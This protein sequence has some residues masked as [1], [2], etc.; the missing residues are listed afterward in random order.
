MSGFQQDG[1]FY[2]SNYYDNQNYG[3]DAN[4]QAQ[5]GVE[6][7]FGQFDYSQG[8]GGGNQGYEQGFMA[9]DPQ[10]PFTGSIMTPSPMAY[11]E[12]S[13]SGGD[14]YD[15][16]PPLMEELGINFD[17]IVQKPRTRAR[18][19]YSRPDQ[20]RTNCLSPASLGM[21][22]LLRL[23]EEI[24]TG[25][26]GKNKRWRKRPSQKWLLKLGLR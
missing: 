6:P 4:A 18:V 8:Y 19:F 12:K 20:S 1:E 3:Y 26:S 9:P 15:D 7:Q 21:P 5:F 24:G 16:E 13:G 11:E 17:H 10:A 23:A 25:N 14:N 22:R 2:Q